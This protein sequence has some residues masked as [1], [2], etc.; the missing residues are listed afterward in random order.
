MTN[1]QLEEH[2]L[3]TDLKKKMT[4]NITAMQARQNFGDLLNRTNL[5]GERFLINRSGKP[6]A[7]IMSVNDYKDMEDLL[8]TLLEEADPDF[9]KALLSSRKEYEDGDVG[10]ENDLWDALA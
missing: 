8:D 5:K 10:S 1:Y 9:Q 4:R 2:F 6:M 3:K 7:I